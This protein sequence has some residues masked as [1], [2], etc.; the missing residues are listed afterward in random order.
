[1]SDSVRECVADRTPHKGSDRIC[2]TRPAAWVVVSLNGCWLR[3]RTTHVCLTGLR[4][5]AGGAQAPHAAPDDQDLRL[6]VHPYPSMRATGQR[7]EFGRD[8]V[9]FRVTINL[10]VDE[11]QPRSLSGGV[12]APVR[13]ATQGCRWQQEG[14]A[15]G[16]S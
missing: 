14:F 4:Q 7:S 8:Q 9:R 16:S 3:S 13:P 2:S 15:C 12:S 1:M 11:E 5:V 6:P 10:A